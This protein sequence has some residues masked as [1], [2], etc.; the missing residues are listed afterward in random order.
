MFSAS[1][2]SDSKK[3]KTS[4]E[5]T[6]KTVKS[7]KK[8]GD[9]RENLKFQDPATEAQ[10]QNWLP[11]SIGA[12]KRSQFTKTRISQKDIASA[13]AI[14]THDDDTKKL[15]IKIVDGASKDGLLAIQSHYMAQTLELNNVKPSKYD[16]TYENNGLKVLESYVKQDS[17]Y[18]VSFLHNMRFGI[19]IESNG[20]SY[21]EVW[22]VIMA[23]DLN[24]LNS[25]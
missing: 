25:L 20:L 4:S 16:K 12:F 8:S 15:E 7:Q 24:K 9:F 3:N 2:D 22:Q 6:V 23:L 13:G 17:F 21:D 14:Y 19:T 11:K 10:F 5:E 18:R 1:C